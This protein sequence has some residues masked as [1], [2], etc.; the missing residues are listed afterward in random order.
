MFQDI[1]FQIIIIIYTQLIW[2]ILQINNLKE[3]LDDL[4]ELTEFGPIF[5]N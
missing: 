1:A 4:S 5:L 2:E 3:L